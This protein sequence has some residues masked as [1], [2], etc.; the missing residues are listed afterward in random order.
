MSNVSI[1]GLGYVG[2]TLSCVL[3]SKGINCIAVDSDKNKLQLIRKGNIPFV[4]P[5]LDRLLTSSIENGKLKISA[6]IERAVVGTDATFITVGTP[7]NKDGTSNLSHL[8]AV[9]VSIGKALRKKSRYHIVIVKS[10]VPPTT[11]SSFV[12]DILEKESRKTVGIDFGLVAN[13]EFLREGSAVSDTLNPH[14]VVIGSWDKKAG[15]QLESFYKKIHKDNKPPIVRTNPSTAEIIKYANNAFL[16]TKISFIN[17]IAN[18]CQHIPGVDVQ[19]VAS[20]IGLDP[21]I[22]SLFLKAGPGYGGSC[23]PKDLDAL[24]AFS[25]KRGYSPKLLKAVKSTNTQQPHITVKLAKQLLGNLKRKKVSILGVAFKKDTNDVREAPSIKIIKQLLREGAIVS[26][27]D[28]LALDQIRP[29]FNDK[30]RFAA[31]VSNC[32]DSADCC[33]VVTDWDEYKLLEPKDFKKMRKT[34]IIDARRVL[35]SV[36]FAKNMKFAAIGLGNPNTFNN[37]DK[38]K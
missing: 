18:I 23:L 16:A 3:A 30:I 27:H 13:P 33:I 11:T 34:I 29:I 24:V 21:R 17:C 2:L 8:K 15:D 4:E 28:P 6:D 10:T 37:R 1:I 5:S 22:G 19:T 26:V 14:A 25:E 7:R 20:T 9:C 38:G 35:N 36:K 32:I 12:K 31:S